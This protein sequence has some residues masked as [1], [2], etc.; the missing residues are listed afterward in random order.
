MA[1]VH[2]AV[3][4]I[5]LRVGYDFQNPGPL[6]EALRAAGSGLNLSQSH[7]TIDGNKRL[8]Q[9]GSAAMKM[10]VLGDWYNSGA[11]R[12]NPSKSMQDDYSSAS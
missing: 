6:L 3:N 11:A 9:L 2:D 12:G 10:V 5:Q 7:A 1:N 4:D 8:A